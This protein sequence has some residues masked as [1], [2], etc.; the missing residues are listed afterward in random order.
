[1]IS[2]MGVPTASSCDPCSRVR[3]VPLRFF[4]Q[5][6]T[7][8]IPAHCISHYVILACACLTR[9]WV[10]L[11]RLGHRDSHRGGGTASGGG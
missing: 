2:L 5:P 10:L 8:P 9:C 4:A 3:P 11:H 1:M 7:R 6:H